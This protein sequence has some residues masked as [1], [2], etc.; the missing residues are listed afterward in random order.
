[1][2]YYYWDCNYYT[3][4]CT[5]RVRELYR[6]NKNCSVSIEDKSGWDGL[7]FSSPTH[8]VL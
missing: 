2:K 1:M 3:A 7:D 4:A 8:F 6:S 5:V